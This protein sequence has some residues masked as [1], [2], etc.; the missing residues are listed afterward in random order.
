MCEL[1]VTYLYSPY[2]QRV[3]LRQVLV[4]DVVTHSLLMLY[5]AVFSLVPSEVE[6][7]SCNLQV[8]STC[9]LN[10]RNTNIILYIKCSVV[11]FLRRLVILSLANFIN[12][13]FS[14]L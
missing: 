12:L 1:A 5:L 10:Y 2:F 7:A 4:T 14:C 6:V 11:H 8:Y 13:V 3:M 9:K